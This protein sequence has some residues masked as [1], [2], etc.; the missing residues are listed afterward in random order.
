[1]E[2]ASR[3]ETASRPALT[4]NNPYLGPQPFQ[5]KHES[6]FF[7]RVRETNDFCSLVIARGEVLL[8]AQS[9]AGK[10]SLLNAGLI[11][12]MRVKGFQVRP[13]TRVSG[14]LPAEITPGEISNLYMFNALRTWVDSPL[15][16]RVLAT[17]SL[18]DF[19]GLPPRAMQCVDAS[20]PDDS[21]E[22]ENS[23]DGP[24]PGNEEARQSAESAPRAKA[25]TPHTVLIFD[26]LE[27]I[28]EYYPERRKDRTNFFE[29]VAEAIERDPHLRVVFSIR[30]DYLAQ[31]IPYLSILPE[32]M[33]TR[34]RLER[35]RQ[36]N[37]LAAIT[38][39]PTTLPEPRRAFAPN[40]AEKL[41]EELLKCH[42]VSAEGKPV[43]VPGEY[44]E[45][46]QLQV[47]CSS[48]WRKLPASVREISCENLKNHG[49]VNE[50]LSTFYE[51]CLKETVAKVPGVKEGELRKW[52][53]QVL[54]TPSDTRGAVFRGHEETG[55][56]PNAAIAVLE[57]LH[58]IRKEER[59][60]AEWYELNHDRFIVPIQKSNRRWFLKQGPA[61]DIMRRLEGRAEEW[62]RSGQPKTKLLIGVE[63]AEAQRWLRSPEAAELVY[64]PNVTT[65]VSVSSLEQERRETEQRQKQAEA[66][67]QRAEEAER[68]RR[69]TAHAH[70]LA[71]EQQRRA[72]AERLRAEEQH[73]LA[74]DRASAATRV[75][76][77]LL[78]LVGVSLLALAA[79][80]F[81]WM[82]HEHED[83]NRE[84]T[85]QTREAK[86]TNDNSNLGQAVALKQ[87][88]LS[89]DPRELLAT[90][91][92]A[93]LN[94]SA[95]FHIT[96]S[97]LGYSD[98]QRRQVYRFEIWPERSSIPG[99]AFISY[100][101][102]NSW[103][104]RVAVV[105]TGPSENFTA[106]YNGWQCLCEVIAIIEYTDVARAPTIAHF[107]MC[108]GL[109]AP[110]PGTA[111]K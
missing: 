40:V 32:G 89:K 41:V 19:L 39:P 64:S 33:K 79:V 84:Q 85:E 36:A 63:L 61:V 74:E 34:F 2:T 38:G 30:E 109:G 62:V 49:D 22:T 108:Q 12:R 17:K 90:L 44:V 3:R 4:D 46:V 21:L 1:M 102:V 57:D 101:F 9:G 23:I 5:E 66:E 67:R 45:P 104:S 98:R 103:T 31:L 105:M 28:F 70:A 87:A 48:L 82:Q 78:A 73:R 106:S 80:V 25:A 53:G 58:I 72:E 69:E 68:Q 94:H 91:N 97:G 83:R 43:E 93:S 29:Q 13:T 27:E 20:A 11:P 52:F 24:G 18:G 15:D 71:E 65:L 81:A 60:G 56:I 50:A 55:G 99:V 6:I 110:W 76:R 111:C 92:P 26:Q 42:G 54:I 88:A 51:D 47:V 14:R 35:L 7:G 10:S 96:A 75:R 8:Y 100:R 77:L 16:P 107:N 37:A 95:M 59:A 86:I